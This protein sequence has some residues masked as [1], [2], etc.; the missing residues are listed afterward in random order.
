ML[1]AMLV[2]EERQ[3]WI[4]NGGFF[5]GLYFLVQLGPNTC[6]VLEEL[7]PLRVCDCG[8][9]SMNVSTTSVDLLSATTEGLSP[10]SPFE[11]YGQVV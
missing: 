5:F 3:L 11:A 4:P 7:P 10:W 2:A 9:Q 8:V 6:M 1:F